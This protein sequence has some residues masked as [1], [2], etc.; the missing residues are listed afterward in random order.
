MADW[1]VLLRAEHIRQQSNYSLLV[2]LG[3]PLLQC[4]LH[5][6]IFFINGPLF[7]DEGQDA[8][9]SLLQSTWG[10]WCILTW[11]LLIGVL[12]RLY[13][14]IEHD[15]QSWPVF[16]SLG[17]SRKAFLLTKLLYLLMALLC[18]QLLLTLG[19]IACGYILSI[20][21]PGLTFAHQFPVGRLMRMPIQV[22]AASL[23]LAGIHFYLALR[24]PQAAIVFGLTI[25][26]TLA[27]LLF[28]HNEQL[29]PFYPWSHPALASAQVTG[30]TDL[31]S[32]NPAFYIIDYL[33]LV[34]LVYS[35]VRYARHQNLTK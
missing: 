6:G 12:A 1:W 3:F 35:A 26:F 9:P 10:F 11:P 4:L 18:A 25:F 34:G 16:F 32:L 2:V 7:I 23:L 15:T 28:V 31:G 5:F 17:V 33:L 27:N 29:G 13:V 14:G 19:I 20:V 30:R 21:Q 22:M 24:V 8:W